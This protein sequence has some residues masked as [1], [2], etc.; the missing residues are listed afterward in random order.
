ML[1]TFDVHDP[2]A[3]DLAPASEVAARA[4]FDDPAWEYILPST[5]QRTHDL[6]WLMNMGVRYGE[7]F[8][9]VFVTGSPVVGASVWLP[10]GETTITADRLDEVGFAATPARLGPE[11]FAR[12]NQFIG[13]LGERHAGL[14]PEPHWYLM[15]VGVEAA[16]RRRGAGS[17]LLQPALDRADRDGVPCYLETTRA[18]N[19]SFFGH[20][21]F[22]TIG[23][24]YLPGAPR[25][26]LMKRA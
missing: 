4:L 2:S 7:R 17:L 20:L 26:W 24:M 16:L 6:P 1:A 13:R 11:V 5:N 19:L 14:V 21:G 15:M 10:P 8:G 12:F 22:A 9:Q 23:E 3:R 25:T 18:C